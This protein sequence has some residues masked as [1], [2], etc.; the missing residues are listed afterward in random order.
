MSGLLRQLNVPDGGDPDVLTPSR[1]DEHPAEDY[2]TKDKR[3]QTAKAIQGEIF[4]EA[5]NFR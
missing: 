1:A 5:R 2:K 3:V 4:P